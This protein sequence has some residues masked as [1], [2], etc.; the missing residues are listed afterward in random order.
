M[1]IFNKSFYNQGFACSSS[2]GMMSGIIFN[3]STKMCQTSRVIL[4]EKSIFKV[5]IMEKKIFFPIMTHIR[6][7]ITFDII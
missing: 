5:L 6:T 4:K 7:C 2:S 3:T 1:E